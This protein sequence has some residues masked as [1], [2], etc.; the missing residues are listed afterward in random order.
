M[1]FRV[2]VLPVQFWLALKRSEGY[3]CVLKLV[4]LQCARRRRGVTPHYNSIG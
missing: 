1:R 2:W 3:A 4:A